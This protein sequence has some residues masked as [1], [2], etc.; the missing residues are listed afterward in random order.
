MFWGWNFKF[1]SHLFVCV[2]VNEG[3]W[4]I[5]LELWNM[6]A[7][8]I[9]ATGLRCLQQPVKCVCAGR[10]A[11]EVNYQCCT[12]FSEKNVKMSWLSMLEPKHTGLVNVQLEKLYQ[13]GAAESKL[14]ADKFG[15]FLHRF[16]FCFLLDFFL[17]LVTEAVRAA[18]HQLFG[19]Y[20]IF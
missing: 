16:L 13:D 6:W 20:F 8:A 15:S 14:E 19:Q 12:M 2:C 1:F 3:R 17:S 9:G 4:E 18:F 7:W 11:K 5:L 10:Y